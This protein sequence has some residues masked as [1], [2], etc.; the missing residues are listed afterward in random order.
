MK[1]TREKL[2]CNRS[3]VLAWFRK[4]KRDPDKFDLPVLAEAVREYHF[5]H[6]ESRKADAQRRHQAYAG[7]D[8]AA[9]VIR[10]AGG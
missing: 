7:Y 10:S 1:L 8:D 3:R 9:H 6:D 2:R 5:P 4:R